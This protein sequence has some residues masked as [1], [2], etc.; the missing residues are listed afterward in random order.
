[1]PNSLSSVFNAFVKD[2]CY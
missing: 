1:M 2:C